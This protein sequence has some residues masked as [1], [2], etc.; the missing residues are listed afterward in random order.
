MIFDAAAAESIAQ[1]KLPGAVVVVGRK[2]AILFR[3]A[4]GARALAPEVEPM[5]LDTVFDLASLTK[6]VATATSVW[7]LA[8]RGALSVD[9]P[10]KKYLPEC[11]ALGEV[12]LRHLL[13]HVAGLPAD[14]AV[15]DYAE[16]ATAALGRGGGG[17]HGGGA[18]SHQL[19][20][21]S[22]R[23]RIPGDLAECGQNMRRQVWCSERL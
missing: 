12:T 14:T 3:K 6:A 23:S 21:G 22:I 7:V 17:G 19:V 8:D 1:Q 4:Y 15:S 18:A 9:D 2:D 11:A 20:A 16:G 5:P 13:T 10:V